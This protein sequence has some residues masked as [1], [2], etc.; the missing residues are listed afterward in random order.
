MRLDVLLAKRG[1]SRSRTEAQRLIH[2][3]NV[4]VNG[5]VLTQ[6]SAQVSE[7]A[8]VDASSDCP[9]VS[10]GGKK[11]EAALDAFSLDPAGQVCMDIGAS[12][13]GFTDCL[14]QRGAKC[15][16]AVENG[17]GQLA[18]TLVADP[19]VY[20]YEHYHAKNL[21]AADFPELPTFYTMD[22][23]F[24]SQTLL[25]PSIAAVMP[26][27]ARL[28]SLIKPQFEAGRTYIGRNGVVRSEEGRRLACERVLLSARELSLIPGKVIQ[29][30]I[31]G[32]DGNREYL[33]CFTKEA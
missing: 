8:E 26:Q 28:V 12:T 22:V 24:I 25:L 1:L 9:Y 33:V 14:L 15:V 3:G 2:S 17:H 20:S 30:P 6:C 16:Y 27:G 11:L 21:R 7:D 10:R 23:S 18:S 19:R 31:E 13:G 4:R 5:C 29:S 32:G